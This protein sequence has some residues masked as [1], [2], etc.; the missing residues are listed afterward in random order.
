SRMK[1]AEHVVAYGFGA[2][3]HLEALGI[4]TDKLVS[5]IEPRIDVFKAA[6]SLRDLEQCLGRLTHL[7]VGHTELDFID[8]RTEL[9]V[10]PQTQVGT[11]EFY[12]QVRNKFYGV[13]GLKTLQPSIAVLGPIQGGTLPMLSYCTRALS[14]LE[15]RVRPINMQEFAQGYHSISK[16]IGNE[17]LQQKCHGNYIEMLSQVVLDS[18]SEKP[19]D[20]LLVMAQAPLSGRALTELRRQG[21]TTALWFVEDY[22][23]FNTWQT[24]APFYDFIFTIQRGPC[25]EAIKAAGCQE[26]HYVPTAADPHVHMPLQVSPEERSRWGSPISFL[27]AGYHNRV[28]MFA[29]LANHPFKIWGT[30]W[31]EMKPFDRLVQEQGRRLSPE[32]YIKI[33]NTTDININLH[34][35]S[36]RD[37]VDPGGDFLN[38]RT[39]ELASCGAFQLVDPREYLEEV[40]TPGHDIA[41]FNDIN[42]LKD[43]IDYYLAHPDERALMATRARE[44]VLM[45]HTYE[46]RIKE[47]L[48]IIYSARFEHLQ[49]RFLA[50]PWS[51]ILERSKKEP[52]LHA[53]CQHAFRRGE[54]PGLDGLLADIATGK[55]A[56]TETEQKLLFMFH[57]S[58]QM[59]RMKREEMGDGK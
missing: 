26:V 31:P 15:Q 16:I 35:S 23:R 41:T 25:I 49:S 46:H 30:E 55:G 11:N 47:M 27:G 9:L 8:E 39:F 5:A 48:S 57:I 12:S 21:V 56:L 17:T 29:A 7:V 13:R 53:R 33:F 28:Q 44:N 40:F 19:I 37:G 45:H 43:K 34:S 42:E 54:E 58:K 4:A 38:P 22:Q 3:Y 32:E 1:T 24:M 36:E 6:L 59:I 2:G 51:R 52:E 50:S 10:R 18:I 14:H 20:I